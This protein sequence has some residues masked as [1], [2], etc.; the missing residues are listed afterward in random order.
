MGIAGLAF[1][2]ESSSTTVGMIIGAALV[3][4]GSYVSSALIYGFAELIE[5]TT[6]INLQLGKITTNDISK[7][8]KNTEKETIESKESELK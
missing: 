7:L 8:I 1:L 6:S 4:G 5:R 2:S 3:L